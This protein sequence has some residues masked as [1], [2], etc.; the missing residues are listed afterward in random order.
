MLSVFGFDPQNDVHW[1]IYKFPF[2]LL[3]K[4][5]FLVFLM[6]AMIDYTSMFFFLLH[7]GITSQFAVRLWT[8]LVLWWARCQPSSSCLFLTRSRS[9]IPSLPSRVVSS[10]RRPRWRP[11]SQSSPPGRLTCCLSD[12]PKNVKHKTRNVQIYV[13]L[14]WSGFTFT[15]SSTYRPPPSIFRRVLRAVGE[16]D[17]R[18]SL[19]G[20]ESG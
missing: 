10:P 12:S 20:S 2:L 9:T 15:F 14:Y 17:K 4:S 1:I 11:A 8:V 6:L 5:I 7:A 18:G 16:S 19:C 3:S 13:R